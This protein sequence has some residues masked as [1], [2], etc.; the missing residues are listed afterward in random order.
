MQIPIQN[1][2]YILCYAWNKLDEKDIVDVDISKNTDIYNLFARIIISGIS[3]LFKRGA[4]REYIEFDEDLPGLKGKINFKET[5]KKNLFIKGKINC[6]YDELDY[7]V[8]QNQILKAIT[9][10]LLGYTELEAKHKDDLILIHQRFH[11]ITDINLTNKSFSKV[12]LHRNNYFYD[13]LL[14][15]CELIFDNLLVSE[16]KGKSKFR[17]FLQDDIKMRAVFEEFLR[18]FYKLEQYEFKVYRENITWNIIPENELGKNFLPE[19]QTDISL[20]SNSRKIIMD[21]KYYSNIFTIG[22]FGKE[23]FHPPNL[24]QLFSYLKNI[25]SKGGL[26]KNCAGVLI[27]PEV[28]NAIDQ[29]YQMENHSLRIATINLMDDWEKINENLLRII[30]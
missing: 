28:N 20:E 26:N 19:M 6:S 5:I 23:I 30:T 10:I 11:N 8:I 13:F 24:Y 9:K 25:E 21:A 29:K 18:N 15:I 1:I 4:D 2:Y 16:E 12:K 7:D 27:Y 3:R 14:K 17:D 22:Q